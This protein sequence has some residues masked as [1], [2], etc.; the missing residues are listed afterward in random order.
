MQLGGS[1][2]VHLH[3]DGEL[4]SFLPGDEVPEWAAKLITNPNAWKP[5]ESPEPSD[6]SEVPADPVD[7]RPAKAGPGASRQVWDDYATSK[8]VEVDPG[9]KRED[10]IAAVEN[11]GF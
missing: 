2:A 9:W 11:A 4:H 7:A 5:S 8:G 3:K 1:Y 6:D 10:I